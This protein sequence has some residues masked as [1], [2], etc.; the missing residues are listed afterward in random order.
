MRGPDVNNASRPSACPFVAFEDDRD[1]R[2]EAP[3]AR[4]RCFAVPN[5]EPR[6]LAHQA[7]YCLTPNFPSCAFFMD[8]AAR[9]AAAP[10]GGTGAGF[11][12]GSAAGMGE[13]PGSAGAHESPGVLDPGGRPWAA[14]PPWVADPELRA[15]APEDSQ[16]YEQSYAGEG[17]QGYGQPAPYIPSPQV[18]YPTAPQSPQPSAFPSVQQPAQPSPQA[19]PYPSSFPVPGGD[20]QQ[21]TALPEPEESERDRDYEL[22]GGSNPD[23]GMLPVPSEVYPA[24]EP[25][26]DQR[27]LAPLA[28]FAARDVPYEAAHA[29]ADDMPAFIL[30]P[31]AAPALSRAPAGA[32]PPPMQSGGQ[33][34]GP[35]SFRPQQAGPQSPPP[36]GAMPPPGAMP[37]S[38]YA[39]AGPESWSHPGSPYG[40]M[41]DDVDAAPP[42]APPPQQR[43]RLTGRPVDVS[44]GPRKAPQARPPVKKRTDAEW[45]KPRRFEAYPTLGGRIRFVSP[46]LIGAFVVAILALLL[47]LLP[48]FLSGGGNAP[49]A[50]R[51][52]SVTA[53]IVPTPT[54]EPTPKSYTVKGG[55]VLS[56]IAKAQ[57][58][59][60]DQIVCFNNLANPDR[61]SI[62][63]VLLIPPGDYVC[64]PKPSPTKK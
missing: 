59:T 14:P 57:G 10:L 5:P 13:Y 20:A 62:G 26:P 55:D 43:S 64:P 28:P 21:L 12:P 4:H 29:D 16:Q 32:P 49:V 42:A 58:V 19:P 39:P 31:T 18:P 45:S 34:A 63:Q 6:A 2:A 24:D 9:A 3:D 33:S 40:S 38:R 7:A 8:W 44:A 48:G 52:P 23:P 41:P 15:T 61:L 51:T 37:P 22:S 60:V 11:A 54:P 36:S 47:F 50:S 53:S 27:P 25:L 1:R 30:P 35:Q 56:T 17:Y 46:V